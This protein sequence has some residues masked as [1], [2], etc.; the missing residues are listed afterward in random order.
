M[1]K[2]GKRLIVSTIAVVVAAGFFLLNAANSTATAP[3]RHTIAPMC[4]HC[5]AAAENMLWGTFEAVS[6]RSENIQVTVG[7][8]PWV[9]RF[10][11]DTKVVGAEAINKIPR[12]REI[13]VTITERAGVLFATNISVKQPITVPKAQLMGIDEMAKLVE[14]GPEKGNFVLVDSRPAARYHEGHI[15]GAIS[16]FD[17]EFDKHTDKLPKAK[18]TLLV[19][20]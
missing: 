3:K 14:M 19:F 8:T 6:M 1:G 18:D 16:I 17:P 7:P 9:V 2:M 20:Y 10:D 13:A 4:M 5:H 15:P 12:A 11:K